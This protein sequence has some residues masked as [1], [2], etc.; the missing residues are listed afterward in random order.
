MAKW[1]FLPLKRS[2]HGPSVKALARELGGEITDDKLIFSAKSDT[3]ADQKVKNAT[4]RAL[5]KGC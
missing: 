4:R 2:D 5:I 3:D 1:F